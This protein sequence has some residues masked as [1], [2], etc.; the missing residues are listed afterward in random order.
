MSSDFRGPFGKTELKVAGLVVEVD[1]RD[2]LIDDVHLDISRVSAQIAFFGS[3]WASAQAELTNIDSNYRHWRASYTRKLLSK[4]EK[5]AEWKMKAEIESAPEFLA[6]KAKIA[7]C[8]RN[9]ILA[10][11]Q[12]DAYETKSRALQ[13]KGANMRAELGSPRSSPA[14]DFSEDRDANELEDSDSPTKIEKLKAK[15]VFQKRSDRNGT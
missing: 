1:V 4:E 6:F 3:V 9:I 2:L 10:R 11:T 12:A 7:E 8:E 14:E 5:L 15:N 13:T